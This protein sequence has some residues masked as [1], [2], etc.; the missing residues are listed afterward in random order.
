MHSKLD[1]ATSL[2]RHKLK[3][4]PLPYCTAFNLLVLPGA[5]VVFSASWLYAANPEPK[6]CSSPIIEKSSTSSFVGKPLESHYIIIQTARCMRTHHGNVGA[7]LAAVGIVT[8]AQ[9]ARYSI[10]FH[11]I[12]FG[13]PY[14]DVYIDDLAVNANL[15]TM[16]EVG[17]LLDEPAVA[18]NN[19]FEHGGTEDP[20]KGG[21]VAARDFNTIQ[22]VNDKVIKSSKSDNI[23]GELFFYSHMTSHIAHIFPRIYC[24]DYIKETS[25]YT[26]HMENR[27]GLTF[28]HL[29]AGR[30]ITKGHLDLFLRI[31]YRIHSVNPSRSA[32]IPVSPGLEE[33]FAKHSL[34]KSE[35]MPNIYENYGTMLRR[36]YQEHQERYDALGPLAASLFARINEFLDTYEAEQRQRMPA[37]Y[38]ATLSLAMPSCH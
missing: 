24:V 19:P 30:S 18:S 4:A 26:I 13:K 11:D 7:V 25:T 17:W 22:S 34:E 28:S 10:P 21:I 14:A 9:L 31:L 2:G 32:T 37:L 23:L 27:R 36:R 8:F 12:H 33:R 38:T 16:Q 6:P 5:T 1:T 20:K 29:L 3:T 15:N 35:H